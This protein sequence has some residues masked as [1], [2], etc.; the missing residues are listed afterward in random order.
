MDEA[1][2]HYTKWKNQTQKATYCII[3]IMQLSGQGKLF[4]QKSNQW[5][6]AAGDRGGTK[7]KRTWGNF[8]GWDGNV[9]HL[10]CGGRYMTV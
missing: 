6:L 4:G 8:L 3:P 10:E 9:L 5:L 2:K 7:Y 1:Q